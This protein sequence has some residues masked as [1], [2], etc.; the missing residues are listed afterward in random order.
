MVEIALCVK[1]NLA[2]GCCG[3]ISWASNGELDLAREWVC[4]QRLG[5]DCAEKA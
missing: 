2:A 5:L 4:R 1:K 3:L